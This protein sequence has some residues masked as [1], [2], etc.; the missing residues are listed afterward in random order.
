MPTSMGFISTYP[1]TQCGIATFSHSLIRHAVQAG[2]IA[3]VIRVIDE[4]DA[5]MPDTIDLSRAV[6]DVVHEWRGQARTAAAARAVNDFD[7]AVIQHEYGIYPGTDGVAILDLVSDLEIPV[8]TALHTVVEH[9][10]PQQRLIMERLVMR[11]D[12]VVTMSRAAR[13]RLVAGY[14]VDPEKVNVIPHGAPSNALR[15]V[16]PADRPRILTWGLL[17][18]GKGVEWAIAAMGELTDLRPRPHYAVV[19]QTHPRVLERDG[20]AYED[21][22]G[23]IVDDLGLGED[24]SFDHRYL[25][26]P[27]LRRIVESAD[28][29]LLPYDSV[30]QVTS[31]VL[32]EA[33]AA[34]KPVVATR[35][36]HAVELL[37]SGAGI[38]VPQRDPLAMAA[39]LRRVLT[40]PGLMQR[41]SAEASRIAP[42]LHWSAVAAR[43]VDLAD[44]AI[45]LP[46]TVQP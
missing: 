14:D 16:V 42:D 23:S 36:P 41:M 18:P 40:E 21:M 22:L 6:T 9:P 33:V 43:Y 25:D 45:G 15:L 35:F 2:A 20:T 39:A 12:A 46:V 11:S 37:A 44:L 38:T 29:V 26:A 24:V 17:G 4:D 19:G 13:S 7:V 10:T 31:G 8:I 28:I 1:P 3:G 34:G 30:D 32:I 27:T 5:T